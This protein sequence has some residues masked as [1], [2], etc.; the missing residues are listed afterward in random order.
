MPP[1]LLPPRPNPPADPTSAVATLAASGKLCPLQ[2]ADTSHWNL[3]SASQDRT[4]QAQGREFLSI[5][6]QCSLPL[7]A[8]GS[9]EK[10]SSRYLKPEFPLGGGK[11]GKHRSVGLLL[12]SLRPECSDRLEQSLFNFCAFDT[13][14]RVVGV[15]RGGVGVDLSRGRTTCQDDRKGE[16]KNRGAF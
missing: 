12:F 2:R 7:P 8:I 13:L 11:P 9:P 5:W 1:G 6:G 4:P 10:S 3:Q 15:G 14:L 16:G